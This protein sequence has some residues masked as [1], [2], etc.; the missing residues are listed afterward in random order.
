MVEA[1]IQGFFAHHQIGIHQSTIKNNSNIVLK[2]D[3]SLISDQKQ[4]CE[5]MNTFYLNI[6]ENTCIGIDCKKVN[7]KVQGVP[8]SQTAANIPVNENHPSIEKDMANPNLNNRIF[9]FRPV[10]ESQVM[11]V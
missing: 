1:Q 2:Q 9:E 3:D 5:K 10:T 6:A 11:N 4:V 7:R 8:Q